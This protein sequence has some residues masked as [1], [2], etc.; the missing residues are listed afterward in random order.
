[1][2]IKCKNNPKVILLVLLSTLC[3]IHTL[4]AQQDREFKNIFKEAESILLYSNS[5]DIALPMYLMLEQMDPDNAN[6]QYKIG[7]CYLNIP[8]RKTSSIPYLEKAVEN[9]TNNYSYNYKEREAPKDALFYLGNAYHIAF[10]LDD[11]IKYYK[12]FKK[13]LTKEEYYQLDFINQEIESCKHA[14]ELLKSPVLFKRKELGDN[15]NRFQINANPAVSGNRKIL[16]YTAKLGSNYRIMCSRKEGEKWSVPKDI[17][18]E[19][20]AEED[21]QTSSLSYDGTT[22]FLFKEDYGRAD[23]YKSHFRNGRWTEIEDL[24]RNINTKYWESNCFLSRDGKTLYFSSNKEDGYGGLDIYK[25]DLLRDGKWGEPKNLGDEINTSLLEDNP[26]LSEDNNKLYFS[27][28]GHY[29]MGRFD[30]F[31]SERNSDNS[32]SVPVNI[33]YPVNSTD[34]DTFLVP[35]GNGD[36]VYLS[37]FSKK[38]EW[39]AAKNI[40]RLIFTNEMQLKEIIVNGTIKLKDGR[41]ELD[42]TFKVTI[43]DSLEQKT[44][45]T[46]IP[47]HK[48]GEFNIKLSPGAYYFSVSG[49]NYETNREKITIPDN[50]KQESISFITQLEL[51]AVASGEVFTSR[52]LLFDFDKHSLD[53]LAMTELERIALIM[54]QYPSVKF[55]II[56]NTDAIGSSNYNLALSRKRAIAVVD[57]LSS[58]GISGSRFETRGAGEIKAVALNKKPDGT[59]LPEGRKYNRRVDIRL[60]SSDTN[61]VFKTESYVPEHL[62]YA[63]ELKHTI[64]VVKVREKLPDD[65]FDGYNI[66]E[67]NNIRM[68]RANGEFYYTLGSFIQR[69]RAIKVIGKLYDA[70]FTEARIVDDL[71]LTETMGLETKKTTFFGKIEEDYY[72]DGIPVYTIQIYALVSPPHP[73]A[74]KE[75]KDIM[76]FHDKDKYYRYTTGEYKGYTA[77]KKA[78]E[79][80]VEKGFTDAFIRRL[81]NLK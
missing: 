30:F 56:G 42:S 1:M 21:C 31:Y 74:F 39:T 73:E 67:L 78:L 19:I 46:L 48:T 15:I 68:D 47:D 10:R 52:P 3:S 16:A 36:T 13:S 45:K 17:T 32:W 75:I 18:D 2:K 8:G 55:E 54:K 61:L 38:G 63:K 11:A 20:E 40:Y 37:Q 34:D 60:L 62:K 35:V 50:I 44:I 4:I 49:D 9:I 14:E 22:L 25:S 76:V 43:K 7:I 69:T 66:E 27:S 81:S 64:L 12:K 70:G 26:V 59:D 29:N 58:Q 79:K 77:A 23:L 6:I 28:Q 80:I 24:G 51:E 57:Y 5:H 65:Y 41:Q 72:D 33:G 53:S 71:E